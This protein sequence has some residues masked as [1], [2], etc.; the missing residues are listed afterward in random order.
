[1]GARRVAAIGLGKMGGPMA[2]HLHRQGA[3][4]AIFSPRTAREFAAKSRLPPSVRLAASPRDAAEAAD[5]ILVSV[6]IHQ[7][8]SV[9]FGGDGV[10]S[11]L[12]RGLVIEAG[13]S[14]HRRD[15]AYES[16]FA[17]KG[18]HYLDTAVSGGPK[19]AR[20]GT[21]V[22]I[23]GGKPETVDSARDVF[24]A[25]SNPPGGIFHVGPTG[26]GH[27]AKM[28]HNQDEQ[29]DMR[30][31]GEA[32]SLLMA[33]GM[34]FR[35]AFDALNRGACQSALLT[36]A[37]AIPDQVLQ[38][39]VPKVGGGDLPQIAVETARAIGHASP[40]TCLTMNLRRVSRGEM[41]PDLAADR[42]RED[43]R[44]K[45]ASHIL[46]LYNL[47]RE[48][49]P[50]KDIPGDGDVATV[51]RVLAHGYLLDLAEVVSIAHHRQIDIPILARI[52]RAG[53][54]D[55]AA[56]DP[57]LTAA[58]KDL[59][60]Y[61]D[62]LPKEDRAIFEEGLALAAKLEHPAPSVAAYIDLD[63]GTH[64]A[65]ELRTLNNPSAMEKYGNALRIQAGIRNAFGEHGYE[66]AV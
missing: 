61:P 8:E 39:I 29:N 12:T 20:A 52:F 65:K 7:V 38:N 26:Q 21:L 56:L 58:T 27:E 48:R 16:K 40:L 19:R 22:S 11:G 51:A 30:N 2:L 46:R 64:T 36:Y 4:A 59:K 5:T 60:E 6:P 34:T 33:A 24:A 53:L 57:L 3:L 41:S 35:D 9:L 42:A 18:V 28:Y 44:A 1:M 17:G 31:I 62:L 63:L 66:V 50:P 37:G 32:I 45:G 15:A 13:N 25:F 55:K 10:A 43:F 49:A 47:L 54:C 23:V 14:D